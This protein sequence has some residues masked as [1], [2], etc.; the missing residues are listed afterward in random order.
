MIFY[1]SGKNLPPINEIEE[2]R[3]ACIRRL[4][5]LRDE[6]EEK[7]GSVEINFDEPRTSA[8]FYNFKFPGGESGNFMVRW[9]ESIA[10]R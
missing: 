3:R 5:S 4:G 6:F 7:G 10:V 1:Y 2:A 8:K 9:K